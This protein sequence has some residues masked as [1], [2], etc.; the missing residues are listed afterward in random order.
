[1][2]RTSEKQ[3]AVD[4]ILGNRQTESIIERCIAVVRNSPLDKNQQ[5][6]VLTKITQI[7]AATLEINRSNDKIK[8]AQSE[9]K[10]TK[11]Y[12]QLKQLQQKRKQKHLLRR[13]YQLF[14]SLA[15]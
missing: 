4:L 8:T 6:N 10:S 2:A 14:L 15:F 12:T 1:M 9:L 13:F 3:K 5:R 11:Q 7:G